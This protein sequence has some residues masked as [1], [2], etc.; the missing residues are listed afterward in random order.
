[1]QQND[2]DQ[3]LFKEIPNPI[4]QVGFAGLN[5]YEEE[6]K[7]PNLYDWQMIYIFP[8]DIKSEL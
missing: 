1:M 3:Y 2:N 6:E 5:P 8:S 7:C 4:K